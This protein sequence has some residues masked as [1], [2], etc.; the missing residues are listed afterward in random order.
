MPANESG[1]VD[2][3][4]LLRE[5]EKEELAVEDRPLPLDLSKAVEEFKTKQLQARTTA[6]I[7][8][9]LDKEQGDGEVTQLRDKALGDS[10]DYAAAAA[11]KDLLKP[12][13][14]EDEAGDDSDS[15]DKE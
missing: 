4:A 9:V 14:E 5:F 15:T 2:H 3:E 6:A 8:R 11:P 10:H 7:A 1:A 13:G 12:G